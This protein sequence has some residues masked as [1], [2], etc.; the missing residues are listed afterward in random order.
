MAEKEH[1]LFERISDSSDVF[2]L[3]FNGIRRALVT[4]IAP[5]TVHRADREV[6]LELGQQPR[7]PRMV[8]SGAVNK[9]QRRA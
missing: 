8:R 9:Q 7:P 4:A 5:A 6:S 3:A 1:G 2:E